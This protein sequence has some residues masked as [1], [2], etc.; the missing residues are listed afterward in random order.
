MTKDHRPGSMKFTTMEDG[1]CKLEEGEQGDLTSKLQT[2]KSS[3]WYMQEGSLN[4]DT[5]CGMLKC[6]ENKRNIAQSIVTFNGATP[7]TAISLVDGSEE[8]L[9]RLTIA[10]RGSS[11]YT[12]A[13]RIDVAINSSACSECKERTEN[14]CSKAS[15][16]R[17]LLCTQAWYSPRKTTAKETTKIKSGWLHKLNRF[18]KFQLRWFV[19]QDNILRY[20]LGPE[21]KEER[22]KV[23]LTGAD[24]QSME[25]CKISDYVVDLKGSKLGLLMRKNSKTI[26]NYDHGYFIRIQV[27]RSNEAVGNDEVADKS[28]KGKI[29][30]ERRTKKA[31]I[32]LMERV[33][34]ATRKIS[35]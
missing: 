10:L 1:E 24:I 22:G 7:E 21:E 28:S 17:A 2:Y 25:T 27:R 30:E 9:W 23:D 14:Y 5:Y 8:K 26:D 32:A 4:R 29:T 16:A 11:L 33:F 12:L 18:G 6:I 35:K 15:A 31:S 13:G 34:P 20:Y 19:L 3:Y